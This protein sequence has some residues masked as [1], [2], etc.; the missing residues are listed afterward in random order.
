MAS[1]ARWRPTGARCPRAPG[2]SRNGTRPPPDSTSDLCRLVRRS[3]RRLRQPAPVVTILAGFLARHERHALDAHV[4]CFAEA[5]MH[6]AA[7]LRREGFV[8]TVRA[9]H[10]HLP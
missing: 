10:Q 5:R 1:V 8:E 9:L 4:A 3:R 2:P 7:Q 6:D